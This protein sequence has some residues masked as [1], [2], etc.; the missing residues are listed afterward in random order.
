MEKYL[1][2]KQPQGALGVDHS[3]KIGRETVRRLPE[4]ERARRN[5]KVILLKAVIDRG[6]PCFFHVFSMQ[7]QEYRSLI[8]GGYLEGVDKTAG[9]LDI[10]READRID[11]DGSKHQLRVWSHF[12]GSGMGNLNDFEKRLGQYGVSITGITARAREFITFSELQ[13]IREKNPTT[14]DRLEDAVA[15]LRKLLTQLLR[16]WKVIVFAPIWI[17]FSLFKGIASLAN[18]SMEWWEYSSDGSS[19][20]RFL[21]SALIWLVALCGAVLTAVITQ[22]VLKKLGLL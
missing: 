22:W 13:V 16:N 21:R 2:T 1:L 12:H 15:S 14:G 19:G 9:W 4:S 17:P 8:D 18:Y 3:P 5:E 6:V 20:E 10:K 7:T 11:P